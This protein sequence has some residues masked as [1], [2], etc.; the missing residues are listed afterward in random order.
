MKRTFAILTSILVILVVDIARAE[1]K[2]PGD[3]ALP[4][5]D[6]SEPCWIGYDQ[7][8]PRDLPG[9]TTPATEGLTLPFMQKYYIAARQKESD[10]NI[11]WALLA[12][13]SEVPPP[14]GYPETPEW[15][16][17]VP[18]FYL[19]D[20]PEARI[21]PTTRIYKKAMVVNSAKIVGD[22]RRFVDV[23]VPRLAPAES[24][25]CDEGLRLFSMYFIYDEIAFGAGESMKQYV[26]LGA[27]PSF[28]EN[29]SA[30][31]VRET[32]VGWVP[33]DRICRWNTRHALDWNADSTLPDASPRRTVAGTVWQNTDA[34]LR[35]GPIPTDDE[36]AADTTTDTGNEPAVE[37]VLFTEVFDR[38]GVS[39]SRPFEQLR[40]PI[41][42]NERSASGDE[43]EKAGQRFGQDW[44][45]YKVGVVGDFVDPEGQVIAT[46]G[47]ILAM[48]KKMATIEQLLQTTEVLFVIDDTGSMQQWF[49]TVADTIERIVEKL[50]DIDR[51]VRVAVAFYNDSETGVTTMPLVKLTTTV[52]WKLADKVR[53][54]KSVRGGNPREPVFSGIQEAIR[55]ASFSPFARKLVI[56]I[57]DDGDLARADDAEQTRERAVVGSLFPQMQS[58]IEFLA[59]QVYPQ[60]Q[61]DKLSAAR[62]YAT[63]MKAVASLA[64]EQGGEGLYD[65]VSSEDKDKVAALIIERYDRLNQQAEEDRQLLERLKRGQWGQTKIG[66]ALERTLEIFGVDVDTLQEQN[67]VQLFQ[68]GYVWAKDRDITTGI[69]ADTT[70]PSPTRHVLLIDQQ[71][72]E[73]MIDIL[74]DLADER[75]RLDGESTTLRDVLLTTLNVELGETQ[76]ESAT[77]KDFLLKRF[78]LPIRSPLMS[79]DIAS[80]KST[81]FNV[82]MLAELDYYRQVLEDIRRERTYE[83]RQ[84]TEQIAGSDVAVW[85]RNG[86][87]QPRPREFS[88]PTNQGVMYYWIDWEKEW[89]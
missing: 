73:R 72:L 25:A 89:P 27:S 62:A 74:A 2:M 3:D 63:Q 10:R 55:G 28:S 47:R 66:P 1:V 78:G 15:I 17:W 83:Y 82:A 81:R 44:R 76:N 39:H 51:N 65:Y 18:T 19:L 14:P 31:R 80:L 9:A 21:D 50:G 11:T 67:G 5:I 8:N 43:T 77:W 32:I 68:E 71:D 23:V 41:I 86:L 56:V 60:D 36:P 35:A 87:P 48:Q 22:D 46:R 20:R 29:A 33:T 16:G 13:K 37:D 12:A 7:F 58:Q 59:I 49:G 85:R 53:S 79:Q 70:A 4:E 26:L 61:I 42:E 75:D 45:L 57:G 54:H 6:W 30:E 38:N 24:A 84:V 64:K 69:A 88:F 40:F 52:G 34:A